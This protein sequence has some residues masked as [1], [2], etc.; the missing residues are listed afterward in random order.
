MFEGY[1]EVTYGKK[2]QLRLK[3]PQQRV[4]PS[5]FWTGTR[6]DV[7]LKQGEFELTLC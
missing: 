3:K 5:L 2:Q 4:V 6:I 7:P 1:E